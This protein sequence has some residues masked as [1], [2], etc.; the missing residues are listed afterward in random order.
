MCKI[1]EQSDAKLKTLDAQSAS[2]L[3]Q[4]V[5]DAIHRV[6]SQNGGGAESNRLPADFF[7]R[8]S[9]EFGGEPFERP[10]QGENEKREA[11]GLCC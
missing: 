9:R 7:T 8:I 1:A 4:L 10:A 5:R 6:D 11:A 2:Q 3:E